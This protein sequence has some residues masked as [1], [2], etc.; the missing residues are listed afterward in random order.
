MKELIINK[1]NL[2]ELI[3]KKYI[4]YNIN[5]K[6]L[7]ILIQIKILTIDLPELLILNCSHIQ[8]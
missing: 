6:E 7:K 1:D 5:N 3:I 2:Q 8:L 4:E